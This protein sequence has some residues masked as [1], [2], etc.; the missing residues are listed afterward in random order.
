MAT[1]VR[2]EDGVKVA[3]IRRSEALVLD[4]HVRGYLAHGI[5]VQPGD[6]VFDVGANIGLFGVRAVS[7]PD[8]QVFAFEPIP[9]I[10]SVLQNN[11]QLHGDG[12][13]KPMPF[14]V[15][16]EPGRLTFTYFPNSPALSTAH[17]EDWDKGDFEEAVRGQIGVSGQVM[18]YAK[19]VPGFLSSMIAKYLRRGSQTVDCELRTVSQVMRDEN[20]S[21]ID[22]LKVDCE[23]AELDVLRGIETEHWPHIKRVVAEVHDLDGRLEQMMSLL[24]SH[25]FDQIHQEKEEGFEDT[26]LVNIYASRGG[27]PS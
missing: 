22:L 2:L 16:N 25:G 12:R 7:I 23:G 11:A 5:Q 13:L 17:M 24:Q 1:M 15:S 19:L 27:A 8:V 10:F 6:V 9:T 26:P 4:H 21:G 3:C 14:G 20:L 18:W